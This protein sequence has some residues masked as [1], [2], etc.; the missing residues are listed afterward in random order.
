MKSK[1]SYLYNHLSED[2]RCAAAM[3]END[4]LVASDDEKKVHRRAL[5]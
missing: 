3:S 5:T 1:W 2:I 4:V